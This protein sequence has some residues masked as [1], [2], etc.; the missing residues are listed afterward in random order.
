MK[1][2]ALALL[3]CLACGGSYPGALPKPDR[4]VCYA[5]ADHHAQSR[6]DNECASVTSFLQ[7]P[8]KDS[9]LAQLQSEQQACK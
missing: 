6:V 8:A 3:A 9:I 5:V 7:C 2:T 1:R 4:A